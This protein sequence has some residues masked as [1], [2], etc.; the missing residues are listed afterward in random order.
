MKKVISLINE[1]NFLCDS[2]NKEIIKCE[3]QCLLEGIK[4][5]PDHAKMDWVHSLKTKFIESDYLGELLSR[6]VFDVLSACLDDAD[7]VI[8][9]FSTWMLKKMIVSSTDENLYF[10]INKLFLLVSGEICFNRCS[11]I[12]L[13][14]TLEQN[15]NYNKLIQNFFVANNIDC[16]NILLE[17][18]LR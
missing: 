1:I 6:K 2:L 14:E 12:Q 10:L 13:L 5:A 16:S 9:A 15:P 11:A 8:V 17:N 7:E 18:S 3:I 4:I